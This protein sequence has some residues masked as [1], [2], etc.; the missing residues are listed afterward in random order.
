MMLFDP[1]SDAG[2][3]KSTFDSLAWTDINIT[4]DKL[5]IPTSDAG[6]P[7]TLK[8]DFDIYNTNGYF[9]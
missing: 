9:N 6:G 7:F 5:K 2:S 1:Y 4:T 8:I 3:D